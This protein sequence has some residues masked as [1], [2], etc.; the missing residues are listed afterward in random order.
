MAG[1]Y[2]LRRANFR[3]HLLG[4]SLLTLLLFVG[5]T[6]IKQCAYEGF[7]RDEWQQPKR[8]ID[9][10]Q[11]RPDDHVADLGAG[12]GYFTFDLAE[13]VGPG[14]KI[15]AVDIDRDMTDLLA[16]RAKEKGAH[17]V[18]VI[19]AKPYDPLL[20]TAGVDLILSVDAYHHIDNR[21]SYFSNLRKYLRR[22]GRIGIVEFDRRAWLGGLWG[23]Y[24][25]S[26][27]IKREMEQA[28]YVLQ[29]EFDF[30]DRQSFLVF[31]PKNST[32]KPVDRQAADKAT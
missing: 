13:A 30:L 12:S 15:Y 22:G 19:L 7:S 4:F 21:V 23:H 10:L 16:K 17:N 27:F 29:Q 3:K 6:R 1:H 11:I 9:S 8:V 18:D 2:N 5:C 14:G 24:T 20:P 25:P 32:H 31:V 28:G 26:E